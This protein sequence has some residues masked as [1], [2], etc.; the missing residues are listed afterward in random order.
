M[1]R[2]IR[3]I[4]PIIALGMAAALT[5]CAAPPAAPPVAPGVCQL[6]P[7]APLQ[8][9][10]I[11]PELEN[12]ALELSSATVVRVIRPGQAITRDFNQS[13]VNLQLDTYD[14]VVRAYC[15]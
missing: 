11:S 4:K 6:A 8:G 15:G 14:V 1:I 5:A 10:R 12:R 2:P 9:H 7:D 3:T 13:R